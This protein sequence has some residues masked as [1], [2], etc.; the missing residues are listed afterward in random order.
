MSLRKNN[1][2]ATTDNK[3]NKCKCSEVRGS[4]LIFLR[5][6]YESKY[7]DITNIQ[8]EKIIFKNR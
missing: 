1:V 2:V 4:D 6:Q 8:I 3:N 7:E 5:E